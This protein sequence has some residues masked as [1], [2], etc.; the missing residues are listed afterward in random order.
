MSAH[1]TGLLK[2]RF[3][4]LGPL[5][6]HWRVPLCSRLMVSI[7]SLGSPGAKPSAGQLSPRRAEFRAEGRVLLISLFG[8]QGHNLDGP[9]FWE[10]LRILSG[11]CSLVRKRHVEVP[12]PMPS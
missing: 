8:F 5:R 1:A 2:C 10:A 4:V 11:C 7:R 6:F 9:M 3:R 12:D